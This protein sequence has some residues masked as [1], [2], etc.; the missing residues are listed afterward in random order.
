M[1]IE[2]PSLADARLLTAFIGETRKGK[3]LS[4]LR[5]MRGLIGTQGKL[6]FIDTEEKRAGVYSRDNEF[7]VINLSAPTML[8]KYIEALRV[9]E[10]AGYDGV[11]IDSVSREW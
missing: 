4:A 6:G 1:Q 8:E 3:T 5:F 9:F 11:V 2:K 7:D 10:T